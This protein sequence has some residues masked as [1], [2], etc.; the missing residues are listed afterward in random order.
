MDNYTKIYTP[1]KMYL[2]LQKLN[3]ISLFVPEQEFI[4]VHKSFIAPL[5]K[6]SHF[7][8]KQLVIN[9]K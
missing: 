8:R 6:I 9:N 4:I 2:T 1:Q 5:S 7:T 3:S